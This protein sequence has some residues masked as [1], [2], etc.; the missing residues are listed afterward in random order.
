M[1]AAPFLPRCSSGE[2]GWAGN[3]IENRLNPD[4]G[5][6]GGPSGGMQVD[7]DAL[8]RCAQAAGDLKRRP[9]RDGATVNGPT[10]DAV[11]PACDVFSDDY[12]AR[13]PDWL[14]QVVDEADRAFVA[15]TRG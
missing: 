8:R 14:Y 5:G 9:A 1:P 12:S 15:A 7:T 4:G 13:V 6:G 11:A 3:S 2:G 10:D